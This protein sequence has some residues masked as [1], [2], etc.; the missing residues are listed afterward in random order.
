MMELGHPNRDKIKRP[1]DKDAVSDAIIT[2]VNNNKNPIY[3]MILKDCFPTSLS[4]L[5]MNIQASDPV[6]A[7]VTIRYSYFELISLTT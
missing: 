1:D 7:T 4:E 2:V 5:A 6:V 3:N